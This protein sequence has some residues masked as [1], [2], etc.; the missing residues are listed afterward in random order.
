MITVKFFAMLRNLAGAE[1][2]D[3][4]VSGPI[5]LDELKG[6]ITEDFPALREVIEGRSVLISINQE[7]APRDAVVKDGDEVA[8]LP[9]FSGG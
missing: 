6:R 2:K 7:F 5:S 1:G 3:Y 8:F 4:E 9:P